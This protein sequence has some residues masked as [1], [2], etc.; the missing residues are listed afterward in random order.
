MNCMICGEKSAN[1]Q[2]KPRYEPKI[3]PALIN[4]KFKV[5]SCCNCGFTYLVPD[6]NEIVRY[7]QSFYDSH[8]FEGTATKY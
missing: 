5:V 6:I 8:Y 7:I 4:N 2:G 1:L 3:E